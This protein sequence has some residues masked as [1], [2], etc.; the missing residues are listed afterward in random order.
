MHVTQNNMN[1]VDTI[2]WKRVYEYIQGAAKRLPLFGE[3]AV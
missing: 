2:S 1:G 3:G